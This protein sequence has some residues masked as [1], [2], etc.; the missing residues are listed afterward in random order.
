MHLTRFGFNLLAVIYLA[1]LVLIDIIGNMTATG[2]ESDWYFYLSA[3]TGLLLAYG[4]YQMVW[5]DET[6]TVATAQARKAGVLRGGQPVLHARHQSQLDR[7]DLDGD[8]DLVVLLHRDRGARRHPVL[9]AQVRRAGPIAE[10][11]YA[12]NWLWRRHPSVYIAFAIFGLS[13]F[14]GHPSLAS[15]AV[16]LF[17]IAPLL[18]ILVFV[19]RMEGRTRAQDHH[20]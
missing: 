1:P 17:V 10:E 6:A 15:G 14:M 7:P 4:V 13:G 5:G 20:L 12:V 2:S 3:F 16:Y 19:A 11:D 18:A 8:P 9:P